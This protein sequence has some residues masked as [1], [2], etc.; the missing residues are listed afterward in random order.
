MPDYISRSG[1]PGGSGGEGTKQPVE[2]QA[3]LLTGSIQLPPDEDPGKW[4][5]YLTVQNVNPV[6]DGTPPDQA[7]TT[8]GGHLL[9]VHT[10]SEVIGCAVFML[11]DHAFDVI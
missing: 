7:A 3:L 8:I 1:A 11:L 9:S 2:G 5:V 6:P 4:N 10:S